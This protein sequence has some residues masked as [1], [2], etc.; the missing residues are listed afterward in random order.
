MDI[1]LRSVNTRFWDDVYI[2]DLDPIEKLVFLYFLTNPLTNLA[3]I[4]EIS[5]RRIAFDT[6]IDKDMISKIIERFTK[7]NKIY[8]AEGHIAIPNFQNHQKYNP[9]METNVKKLYESLS[10]KLLE[11]VKKMQEQHGGYSVGA[12]CGQ[13][14]VEEEGKVEGKVEGEGKEKKEI[15]LVLDSWNIFAGE[16]G[17]TKIIKLS[18]TRISGI[19]QRMKEKE[20]QLEKI[21][22][23]IQ[24][25]PFLLGN[26]DRGWKVDFDFIFCSKTKYLKILEGKYDGTNSKDSGAS[27]EQL[28]GVVANYQKRT[29]N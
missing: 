11:F 17:L 10:P 24:R 15:F 27:P 19:K 20:F 4:Y 3:G 8:Y 2:V 22:E 25:S 9:S 7:D 26:N 5:I 16:L 29:G 18:D 23:R 21:Y 1:K 14:E 28:A 12:D 13:V 6:G